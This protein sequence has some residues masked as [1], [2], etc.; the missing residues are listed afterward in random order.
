MAHQGTDE[1]RGDGELHLAEFRQLELANQ[2]IEGALDLQRQ[3]IEQHG[4]R[5]MLAG[6]GAKTAQLAGE[7]EP[8]LME[9]Q[10]LQILPLRLPQ[11]HAHRLIRL[12]Q[13]G[14]CQLVADDGVQ[15]GNAVDRIRQLLHPRLGH[16]DHV[17]A[18]YRPAGGVGRST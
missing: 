10:Q 7:A 16:T 1:G 11:Q 2:V 13:R 9:H 3:R 8:A 4:V 5:L 14:H 6:E 15:A 12:V 18:R 17:D